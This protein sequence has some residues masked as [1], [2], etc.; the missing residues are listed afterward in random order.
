MSF[1]VYL[2]N[3]CNLVVAKPGYEQALDHGRAPALKFRQS[4]LTMCTQFT[5]NVVSIS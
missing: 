2:D 1:E 4:T 3:R 5:N